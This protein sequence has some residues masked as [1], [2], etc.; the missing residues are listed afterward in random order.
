M[1]ITFQPPG[2]PVDVPSCGGG[3]ADDAFPSVTEPG[4]AR[5]GPG[6]PTPDRRPRH[7]RGRR[8]SAPGGGSAEAYRCAGR[9]RCRPARHDQRCKGDH[10]SARGDPQAG[11]ARRPPG[12]RPD[13][14]IGSSRG[15][16]MAP[17]RVLKH[18]GCLSSAA[19]N[20]A[21]GWPTVRGGPGV[22]HPSWSACQIHAQCGRD[23][24]CVGRMWR[25]RGSPRPD[26]AG[27][28][29][30]PTDRLRRAHNSNFAGSNPPEPCSRCRTGMGDVTP[31]GQ[32]S[33]G[34]ALSRSAIICRAPSTSSR[35]MS[36]AGLISRTSPTP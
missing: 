34:V 24:P 4:P 7:R 13:H 28:H 36:A 2:A 25:D 15:R 16:M 30:T 23:R 9:R 21:S 26:R 8:A 6:I 12:D 19:S 29:A 1:R 11:E 14:V 33:V 17:D 31:R 10:P 35:T 20:A 18:A 22:P 3:H 27:R 32:L 5:N